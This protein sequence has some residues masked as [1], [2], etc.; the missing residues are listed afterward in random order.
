MYIFHFELLCHKFHALTIYH[1]KIGEVVYMTNWY[2][3]PVNTILDLVLI[4]ARSSVVVHITAGKLVN[5]SV[6]TF[7]DNCKE[8][9]KSRC[10]YDCPLPRYLI[11][12]F[13]QFH[14]ISHHSL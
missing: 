10:K 13:Q 11:I 2:Y 9:Q 1:L 7:G 5:M 4:I 14:Y 6:Y 8:I 3:L 12:I